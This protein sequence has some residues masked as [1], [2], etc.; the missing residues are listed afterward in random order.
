[1]YVGSVSLKGCFILFYFVLLSIRM[2]AIF[3]LG[4]SISVS[5]FGNRA[6]LDFGLLMEIMSSFVEVQLQ[7]YSN[8]L[9]VGFMIN[10]YP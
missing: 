6:P 5:V 1:M 9:V 3:A 8:S 7:F 2:L 10:S 4:N